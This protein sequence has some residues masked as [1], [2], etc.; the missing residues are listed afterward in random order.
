MHITHGTRG[1]EQLL[2]M[3][4]V[5]PRFRVTCCFRLLHHINSSLQRF[6]IIGGK[7]RGHVDSCEVYLQRALTII[8]G[9]CF[10]HNRISPH[11]DPNRLGGIPPVH[12]QLHMNPERRDGKEVEPDD[13]SVVS[14][15]EFNDFEV[16]SLCFCSKQTIPTFPLQIGDAVEAWW[17][18]KWFPATVSDTAVTKKTLTLLFGGIPHYHGGDVCVQKHISAGYLPSKVRP[19]IQPLQPE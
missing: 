18:G 12:I 1:A 5:L 14:G 11:R 2:N 19:R 3:Q 6:K 17:R 13:Q 4:L 15:F 10:L 8:L 9:L 7:Y 16:C